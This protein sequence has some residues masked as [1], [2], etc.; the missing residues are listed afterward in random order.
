MNT[1]VR[2]EGAALVRLREGFAEIEETE[3]LLSHSDEQAS[4]RVPASRLYSAAARADEDP[5]VDAALEESRGARGF[6][7]RAVAASSLFSLPEA[8]AASSGAALARHGEG[9]RIRTEQSR[10]EPDQYFVV[11]EVTT[12]ERAAP[13]SLVVCDSE[14]RVRRFPLPALRN[15]VAQMIAEAD[16]DLLRLIGDPTTKV[17]LR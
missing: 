8:R 7:R 13:T 9:C 12:G 5:T 16:S 11:V 6:Y 2:P 14:D 4:R 10:A 17:F 1:F 15:G 3:A